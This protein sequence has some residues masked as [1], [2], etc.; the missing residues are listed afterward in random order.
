ML[1]HLVQT[2]PRGMPDAKPKQFME[3]LINDTLTTAIPFNKSPQ[4]KYVDI[5]ISVDPYSTSLPFWGS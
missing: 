4:Y 3:C 2:F 1:L 5:T